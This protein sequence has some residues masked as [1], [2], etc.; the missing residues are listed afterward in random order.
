MQAFHM[1]PDQLEAPVQLLHDAG[2]AWLLRK[3]ESIFALCVGC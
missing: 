2:T 3:N 1:N